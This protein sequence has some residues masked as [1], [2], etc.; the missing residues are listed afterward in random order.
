MGCHFLLQGIF[1]TQGPN[2]HP[3]HWQLSSLPL[4]HQGSPDDETRLFHWQIKQT[5]QEVTLYVQ[6]D[7]V[8]M[9]K[10]Q[11]LSSDVNDFQGKRKLSVLQVLKIW[12]PRSE[13]KKI[14]ILVVKQLYFPLR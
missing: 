8:C 1:Q 14:C 7:K 11:D 12:R 3:L 13:A 4:S 6:G 9:Q 5:N 2:W 10:T